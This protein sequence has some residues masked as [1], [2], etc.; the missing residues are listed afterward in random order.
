[1]YFVYFVVY[2]SAYEEKPARAHNRPAADDDSSLFPVPFDSGDP[3][4]SVPGGQGN[5]PA[6]PLWNPAYLG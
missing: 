5:Y 6:G 4:G 2:K 3:G 1:V